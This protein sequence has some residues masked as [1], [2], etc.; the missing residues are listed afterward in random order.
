[1]YSQ[2]IAFN[3][4]VQVSLD[5]EADCGH[6]TGPDDQS[7]ESCLRFPCASEFACGSDAHKARIAERPPIGMLIRHCILGSQTSENNRRAL[8]LKRGA[9]SLM[10]NQSVPPRPV[11]IKKS[12]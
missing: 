4:I 9:E 11:L 10:K 5:R 6:E 1:V 2:V 3:A 8:A 12:I 7:G